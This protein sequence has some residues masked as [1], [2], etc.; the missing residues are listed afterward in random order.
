M[1]IFDL[2]KS[3]G[4]Q[5]EPGLSLDVRRASHELT[6]ASIQ[7]QAHAAI[8]DKNTV[9]LRKLVKRMRNLNGKLNRPA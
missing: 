7:V 2:L 5:V 8:S 4:P 1:R 3:M 9:A 6:S